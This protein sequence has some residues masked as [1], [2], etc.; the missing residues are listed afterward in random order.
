MFK[1]Y[2]KI[3]IRNLL[4]YKGY[5]FINIL[6][7]AIGITVFIFIM[8]FV[9]YEFSA[10]KFHENYDRI[11]R[12]ERQ[13]KFGI[14]GITSLQLMMDN[15]PD[16]ENGTRL[17]RYRGNIKYKENKIKSMPI[18]VD[19][20]FFSIFSFEAVTGDLQTV[21]DDPG[22]IVL[23]ESFS[24]KVFG[25][26]DPIGKTVSFFMLNLTV[27]AVVKDLE[28]RTLLWAREAF[29]PFVNLKE[30]GEDFENHWWGNYET[31]IV[32]PSKMTLEQFQPKLNAC[33]NLMR[34]LVDENFPDHY[35]RPLKELYFE[36]GKYDHSFHGNILTVKIFLASAILIILIACI[37]FVNLST[38]RAILRAKEI[39]VRK[40]VGAKKKNLIFQ[41]LGESIII[42]LITGVLAAILIEIFYPKISDF[43]Q[44]NYPI[45]TL[46]NIVLYIVSLTLLGIIA[47]I[48]PAF[49]LAF[50]FPI[51]VLSTESH[52]GRKGI[53]FRKL[54]TIFQFTISIILITGTI[55][56]FKQLGYIR[57]KDL[58]F[59]KE[60][61]ISFR[62]PGEAREKRD[63]FKQELLKI[64]GVKNISYIYTVPGRVVLQWGYTDEE[65][66]TTWFRC[67]PTDP[68]FVNLYGIEIVHGRNFDWDLE[69]D[70][71]NFLV[72]EAF[73]KE[74]GW[75]E[76]VGHELYQGTTVIGVVKDF[77]YRS[78]H[79]EIEPLIINF[80]W[81]NTF[82]V[83][84]KV[85]SKNF[86]QIISQVQKKYE[87]Y[88]I[89]NPFEYFFLDDDF[90]ILYRE[91][92]RFGKI[93]GFFSGLSIFVACLGLVG[94]ASFMTTQRTKEIGVRKVLG[95]SVKG[96]VFLL[97]K[98]FSKNV[99]YASII[100]WFT[101]YYIMNK[102]LQNFAFRTKLDWWIFILSGLTAL[103]IALLTVSFQTIKA[104]NTNPVEALKYE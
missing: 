90:N 94:L 34:Q 26:E 67:L 74:M 56:V 11:Y 13:E 101:A 63:V 61:I 15:I 27:K 10:D 9:N 41:F 77:I 17:M 45:N 44:I 65:E 20:T 12:V 8:I 57:T 22:A 49:H 87:E 104:A 42:C 35:L 64:P 48:Y 52:K 89:E 3:A 46:L 60:Q 47:G 62:I 83:N 6:G 51:N 100:A 86:E 40:I 73:V 92:I 68:E 93:F 76:P 50:C 16:I 4:K 5:S 79:F 43:F 72:N 28:N 98:D 23:T 82:S 81:G 29:I 97:T 30:L 95:S 37:N 99:L 69:T 38:A 18:F 75:D 19:S 66:N 84:L 85:E 88:D 24:K 36:R 96:I 58:G 2:I 14:T 59:D 32:L 1:N 25:D 39:G 21:L 31:Y 55:I 91:D 7:L 103:I 33:N 70:R 78:L 80:D 53:I 54:L 71:G 102:W